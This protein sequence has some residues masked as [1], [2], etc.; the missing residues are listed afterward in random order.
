MSD[1]QTRLGA[2]GVKLRSSRLSATGKPCFESV[3]TFWNTF[4]RNRYGIQ[5]PELTRANFTGYCAN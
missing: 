1:V 4:F 5:F 2:V 3:V